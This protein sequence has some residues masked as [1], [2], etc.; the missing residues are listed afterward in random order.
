MARQM[1]RAAGYHWDVAEPVLGGNG[2]P[3]CRWCKGDVRPPRRGWCGDER[4][5]LEW[6]RRT[7]W[8]ITRKVIFERDRGV[9]LMCGFDTVAGQKEYREAI[10]AKYNRRYVKKTILTKDPI[11]IEFTRA[12]KIPIHAIVRDGDWWEVDHIHPVS[13]GGDWFDLN[14]LRTLCVPC[15]AR[16]TAMLAAHQAERRRREK[17]IGGC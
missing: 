5:V 15:H 16:A 11:T 9:C 13:E 12:T 8:A 1:P 6:T 7:T 2:R 10:F 14:N 17:L 3:S 4:C